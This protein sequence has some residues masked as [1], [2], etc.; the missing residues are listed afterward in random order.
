MWPLAGY[1]LVQTVSGWV[2]PDD[3]DDE[4]RPGTR[5]NHHWKPATAGQRYLLPF[6]V[7]LA[8]GGGILLASIFET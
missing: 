5:R 6:V 7:I 1:V 3:Y 2:P 8:V 4:V